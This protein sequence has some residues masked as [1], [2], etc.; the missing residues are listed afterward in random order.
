MNGI[1]YN[2][3]DI[4]QSYIPEILNEIY[5][6]KIYEPYLKG[7]KNLVIMDIGA[8]QGLTTNYFSSF[9]KKVYSIEPSTQHV[10]VL[11]EMVR[12]NDLEKKVVIIQKAVSNE[13]GTAKFYFND[14]ITSFSLKKEVDTAGKEPEIVETIRLDTLFKKY[15]IDYVDFLKLDIEGSEV[16][17]IGGSG[18]ENVAD[19][20]G[21]LVV[22]YHKWSGRNPSQLV[23]TLTDYGFDMVP[24][25]S[26]TLLFGGIKHK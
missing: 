25:K 10:E 13:N 7:R 17:V 14:N 11:K 1:F 2:N 5:K 23:T 6:E 16:D 21:S 4:E 9:A 22:E 12:Y 3:S 18:F 26:K 15:N 19:K 20:I 24:I 8:N